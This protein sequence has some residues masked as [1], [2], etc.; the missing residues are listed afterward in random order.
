MPNLDKDTVEGFGKEWTRFHYRG[1][2]DDDVCAMFASYFGWVAGDWLKDDGCGADFG[3]GSGRWAA[4]VATRVCELWCIDA[5]EEAL[6]VARTNLA[7][8]RNCYFVRTAIGDMGISDGIFDFGYSLGVLHHVPDTDK[9][10]RDCV[11]T[12]KRGAPFLLYL[13]YALD[14]RPFWYRALWK[15]ANALR[16]ESRSCLQRNELWFVKGLPRWSIGL[17]HGSLN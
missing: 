9:A 10:L 1:Q 14:N 13:Y 2:A 6:D 4:L 7:G 5:S 11:R 17:W 16:L 12:L 15:F 8:E 3:C